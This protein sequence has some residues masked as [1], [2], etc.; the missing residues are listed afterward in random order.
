MTTPIA[1]R[2]HIGLGGSGY[3]HVHRKYNQFYETYGNVPAV[4][5]IT[6]DTDSRE[7]TDSQN[8]PNFEF[9]PLTVDQ[10]DEY[11]KGI[12][13]GTYPKIASWFNTD[14]IEEIDDLSIGAQQS[15]QLGRLAF[16]VNVEYIREVLDRKITLIGDLAN[17]NELQKQGYDISGN[18]EVHIYSSLGGGT[19]SG[20]LIDMAENVQSLLD[21]NIAVEVHTVT[22]DIFNISADKRSQIAANTVAA[23]KE[24]EYFMDPK[25][26][27][28]ADYG[29]N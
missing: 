22:P 21:N 18:L 12:N 8:H 15:R 29:G 25:N 13:A 14:K 17:R 2:L 10:P 19:G 24:V 9:I 16:F 6:F 3:R 5:Y 28:I 1:P 23:F 20:M 27:F 7:K 11:L 4:Q 26:V